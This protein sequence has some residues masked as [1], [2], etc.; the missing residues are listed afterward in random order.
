MSIKK[1][2][3]QFWS[4]VFKDAPFINALM[5]AIILRNN[6]LDT[7]LATLEK[8]LSRYTLDVYRKEQWLFVTYDESDLNSDIM[9]FNQT[10]ILFDGSRTFGSR[11][12]EMR[13]S[14]PVDPNLKN[15]PFILSSPYNPEI[16]LQS[17][18]DYVIENG[19][20]YFTSNPFLMN[21]SKRF[22]ETSATPVMGIAMWFYNSDRD[23]QDLQHIFADPVKVAVESDRYFKNVV[24]DIWNLRIEG[25]TICNVNSLINHITDCDTPRDEELVT[26][27]F[28]EG[29]RKWV[30]TATHLYSAPEAVEVMYEEGETISPCQ[31]LFDSVKIYTGLD[32]IPKA[33]FPA[34]HL[35]EGFVGTDFPGGIT[36]ENEDY[37][38][39]PRK[40]LIYDNGGHALVEDISALYYDYLIDKLNG[41]IIDL[42]VDDATAD[43]VLV[44]SYWDLP[45]RGQPES[46]I[47]FKN[48]LASIQASKGVPGIADIAVTNNMGKVPATINLFKEYQRNIL[49]NNTFFLVINTNLIPTGV[50]PSIFLTY[51]KYTIPA[52]TTLLTYMGSESTVS[53]TASNID[54]SVEAFYMADVSATY[55]TSNISERLDRKGSY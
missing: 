15:I 32:N 53:Y 28:T 54:D 39:P 13:F 34:M 36:I 7:S 16:V 4:T 8:D 20:I 10:T 33:E 35:G 45:F 30:S 3:S 12:T 42:L 25:G 41:Y 23:Y 6:Q 46:V 47:A 37:P 48:Y 5:D 50:D 18:I 11:G 55:E 29:G 9:T 24:N 19:F 31:P 43:Y 14:L 17:G 44:D 38:F 22:I 52:Y 1:Y 49:R 27:I 40:V 51:I 26:K 21:F 2:I